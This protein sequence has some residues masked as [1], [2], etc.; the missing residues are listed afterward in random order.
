M[1]L[2]KVLTNARDMVFM[3]GYSITPL[4][5]VSQP[6]SG[7]FFEFSRPFLKRAPVFET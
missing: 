3:S 2:S 5:S 4:T 6:I 7:F 1:A